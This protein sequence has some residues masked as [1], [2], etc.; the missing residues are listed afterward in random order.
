MKKCLQVSLRQL[1]VVIVVWNAFILYFLHSQQVFS[2]LFRHDLLD[3]HLLT[4]P[5]SLYCEC[6]DRVE[7]KE[8]AKKTTKVKTRPFVMF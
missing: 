2:I 5:W 4:M 7:I 3:L 6:K 1:F 8:K